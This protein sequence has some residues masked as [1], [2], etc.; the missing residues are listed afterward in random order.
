MI[1]C[2]VIFSI[3]NTISFYQRNVAVIFGTHCVCAKEEEKRHRMR[4]DCSFI[5]TLSTE[6]ST[7]S[8]AHSL[9]HS[10]SCAQKRHSMWQ[11]FL[12]TVN[13]II[14]SKSEIL[15]FILL[16]SCVALFFPKSQCSKCSWKQHWCVLLQNWPEFSL[17][18]LQTIQAWRWEMIINQF[19]I[20]FKTFSGLT[21]K[22]VGIGFSGFIFTIAQINFFLSK[23]PFWSFPENIYF[24][25]D[26]ALALAV[27]VFFFSLFLLL[28]IYR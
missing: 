20:D 1:E 10:L 2:S 25:F 22:S 18:L 28:L 11:I 19:R 23:S 12:S 9:S 3:E 26:I 21:E 15:L 17:F 27:C 13:E 7:I 16:L 5:W 6:F 8:Y 14:W 24:Q 4:C